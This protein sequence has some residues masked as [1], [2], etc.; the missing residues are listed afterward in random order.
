MQ[1]R[2]SH[3]RFGHRH[4]LYLLLFLFLWSRIASQRS[5]HGLADERTD[6]YSHIAY[7]ALFRRKTSG[8]RREAL[9][10]PVLGVGCREIDTSSSQSTANQKR[11]GR[12]GATLQRQS[13]LIHKPSCM[14]QSRGWSSD[15]RS[16]ESVSFAV[17]MGDA[18]GRSAFCKFY[19]AAV[20]GAPPARD[21][22]RRPWATLGESRRPS[23]LF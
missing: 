18:C 13:S 5:Q 6:S 9:R 2:W 15:S 4:S 22:T 21:L 17:E 16:T 20:S 7:E 1:R 8:A 3:R 19:N 11:H 10:G 12:Y 23:R 14:L